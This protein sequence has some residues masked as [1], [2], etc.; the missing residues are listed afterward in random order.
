VKG[1]WIVGGVEERK[2][3]EHGLIAGSNLIQVMIQGPVAWIGSRSAATSWARVLGLIAW[4][5]RQS[6]SKLG[7]GKD[8]FRKEGHGSKAEFDPGS[9]H[10]FCQPS[11]RTNNR[12]TSYS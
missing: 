8:C 6:T 1:A 9:R 10:E 4:A 7:I 2:V 11:K 3:I 12:G 5:S